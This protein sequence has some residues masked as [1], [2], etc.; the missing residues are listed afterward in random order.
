MVSSSEQDRMTIEPVQL[1]EKF[2]AAWAI[3][4]GRQ[5][6][7]ATRQGVPL[8][9]VM[10]PETAETLFAAVTRLLVKEPTLLEIAPSSS[11]ATVTVIG[12]T[13]GQL[14]DVVGPLAG[15]AGWPAEDRLFVWNGDFVDRGA[16]GVELLA[17]LAAWKLALPAAVFLLR[18]NHESIT[19]TKMYGFFQELQS[20]YGKVKSKLV[21]KACKRLFAALPLAACI[22]GRTLV[23]HGGLFRKPEA[24]A[25]SKKRRRKP[26]SAA[27]DDVVLGSLADLRTASKGGMDPSGQGS[28]VVAADVMWSDPSAE[29][30]LHMNDS[31]GV[32]VVFGADITEQFL[33][34]NG[35]QLVIRSHEGP[36]ARVDRDDMPP[37]TPGYST[38]HVTE[39]GKLM[40]VFSAPDY[41]QFQLPGER[42]DNLGAV[43]R[44]SAPDYTQPAV[45]QFSASL[46]RPQAECFYD[47]GV[48]DSDEEIELGGYASDMSGASSLGGSDASGASSGGGG[49]DADADTAA[50]AAS[51]L[52]PGGVLHERPA[53]AARETPNTEQTPAVPAAAAPPQLMALED[54]LLAQ[55]GAAGSEP[56]SEEDR[57]V[58]RA[59]AALLGAADSGATS[60][61]SGASAPA[62]QSVPPAAAPAAQLALEEALLRGESG[63]AALDE[64]PCAQ[65]GAA[66]GTEPVPGSAGGAAAVSH[67]ASIADSGSQ[68]G[69]AAADS[70]SM[71]QAPS[72]SAAPHSGSGPHT[73]SMPQASALLE[74]ISTAGTPLFSAA[75]DAEAGP[76]E[77]PGHAVS[78]PQ[79]SGDAAMEVEAGGATGAASAAGAGV[80]PQQQQCGGKTGRRPSGLPPRPVSL[81]SSSSEGQGAAGRRP[82]K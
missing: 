59:G 56:S 39:S 69:A 20:K 16:W 3:E 41:P 23:L 63:T 31:R 15:V 26:V 33:K 24:V 65:G 2:T 61:N 11:A 48:P 29:P 70:C 38:D 42:Y 60:H 10:A 82:W 51:S 44:L 30:G 18:G 72:S 76:P 47:L 53:K 74:Q 32:G 25:R 78:Q 19:C 35:L 80:P 34:E 45:L 36:D 22:A 55:I 17:V 9:Q 64:L 62:P 8:K 52:A 28:T 71:P 75:L 67:Q 6:E 21:F 1:P 81:R 68:L 4:L 57:A 46:P 73:A 58:L 37:M 66:A 77:P 54:E 5:L 12:D 7:S 27:A 14:H 40:T 50:D 79:Q 49:A 43:L 13:H